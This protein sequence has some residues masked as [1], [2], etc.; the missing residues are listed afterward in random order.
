MGIAN[1]DAGE[2]EKAE[3]VYAGNA[4]MGGFGVSFGEN[5]GCDEVSGG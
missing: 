1:G 4:T 2:W 3:G 5:V